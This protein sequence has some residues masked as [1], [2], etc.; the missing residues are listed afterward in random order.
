MRILGATSPTRPLGGS[1]VQQPMRPSCIAGHTLR[2]LSNSASASDLSNSWDPTRRAVV[3]CQY[4][5]LASSVGS[6]WDP[7]HSL[8]LTQ[9]TV[10]PL[11]PASL[12]AS[13]GST[14]KPSSR[15]QFLP[16]HEAVVQPVVHLKAGLPHIVTTSLSV[17]TAAPP[18]VDREGSSPRSVTFDYTAAPPT[19]DREGSSPATGSSAPPESRDRATPLSV[20]VASPPTIDCWDSSP[21]IGRAHV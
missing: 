2:T 21:Q 8:S 9:R 6:T 18:T 15:R 20:S 13:M 14:A 10:A 19:T 1:Y 12:A 3:P 11:Q 16:G 17:S 5:S 4:A 7:S